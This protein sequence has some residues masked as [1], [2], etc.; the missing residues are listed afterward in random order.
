MLSLRFSGEQKLKE[1]DSIIQT[2][3][4]ENAAEVL[5][6]SSSG[7]VYKIKA[8]EIPDGKASVLG[9]Y[10]PN[11][12]SMG[13]G[14]TVVGMVATTDFEGY[15]LFC[16]EN[17]KIAKV[18]LKSY[19]TKL[20]RKK[21]TN[22]YSIASPLVRIIYIREETEL[23]A[24][25][26]IGK[27]L[28]FKTEQIAAKTTK[29]TQGVSVMIP[30]KGS[31]VSEIKTTDEVEFKN[32]QYYRTKNIPAKGCFIKAEDTGAEQLSLFDE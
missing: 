16:F 6:F 27:A 1:D 23:V 18:E 7:E 20:N 14:E 29:N 13:E 11:L 24:I 5:M 17:G 3:D 12:L 21:L 28:V 22:A 31:V 9:E 10:M 19:E 15:V 26:S 25:S 8:H 4:T 30:K 2:I 32:L